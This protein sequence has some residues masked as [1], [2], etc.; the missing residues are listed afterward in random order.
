[1]VFG[2]YYP[3]A[4]FWHR[5]DLRVK[6]FVLAVLV[7]MALL[8]KDWVCAVLVSPFAWLFSPPALPGIWVLH[9]PFLPLALWA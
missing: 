7:A 8:A 6:V 4:S 9:P 2:R 1:M 5:R 3:V